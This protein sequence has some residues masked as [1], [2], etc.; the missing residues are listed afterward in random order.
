M[1]CKPIKQTTFAPFINIKLQITF[2]SIIY[3]QAEALAAGAKVRLPQDFV[4]EAAAG[5]LRKSALLAYLALQAQIG[6]Y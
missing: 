3:L 4:A 5:G 2:Y 6:H 1:Q